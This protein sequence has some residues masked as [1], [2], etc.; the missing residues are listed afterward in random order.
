MIPH[1]MEKFRSEMSRNRKMRSEF[2]GV[3][4]FALIQVAEMQDALFGKERKFTARL[5]RKKDRCRVVVKMIK[6]LHNKRE[7]LLVSQKVT[8][9]QFESAHIIAR[10][11][12]F[13]REMCG[14]PVCE[15]R[16]AKT[17]SEVGSDLAIVCV[18]GGVSNVSDK[19]F[20]DSAGNLRDS[21]VGE[22]QLENA[23]RNPVVDEF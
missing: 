14:D 23:A 19:I 12:I 16:Y 21:T 8:D 4:F 11:G 20:H 3:K 7:C 15:I 9:P 6:P 18:Y 1:V 22:T 5:N 17:R 2:C 13:Y 10:K